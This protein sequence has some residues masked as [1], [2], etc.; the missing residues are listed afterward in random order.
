MMFDNCQTGNDLF[1]IAWINLQP[2]VSETVIATEHQK[3]VS[4]RVDPHDQIVY[5]YYHN[6]YYFFIYLFISLTVYVLHPAKIKVRYYLGLNTP[7]DPLNMLAQTK[8]TLAELVSAHQRPGCFSRLECWL[9]L[10]FP[11]AGIKASN[12]TEWH[13]Q[14]AMSKKTKISI[15]QR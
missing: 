7:F 14:I 11:G 8:K 5:F 9:R 12:S 3:V 2:N 10:D 13:I 4:D 1:S 6:Y 15:A